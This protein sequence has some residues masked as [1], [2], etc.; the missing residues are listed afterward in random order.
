MT[1]KPR[2]WIRTCQECGHKQVSKPIEK[3]K[4]DSWRDKKCNMCGSEALDYGS[5]E[6]TED[7]KEE[8]WGP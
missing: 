5:W 3:Y 6:K 7:E 8:D 4:N 1:D 2:Y